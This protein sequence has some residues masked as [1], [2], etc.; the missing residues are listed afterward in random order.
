MKYGIDVLDKKLLVKVATEAVYRTNVTVFCIGDSVLDVEN[1]LNFD[2]EHDFFL[3]FRRV[4][5]TTFS[6]SERFRESWSTTCHEVFA[7][8]ETVRNV[9]VEVLSDFLE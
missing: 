7:R 3:V 6:L 2:E 8:A 5:K 1:V 4:S 9:I